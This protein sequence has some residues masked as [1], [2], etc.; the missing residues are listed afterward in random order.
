[1]SPAD[2]HLP[3]RVIGQKSLLDHRLE[4][5][6]TLFQPAAKRSKIDGLEVLEGLQAFVAVVNRSAER[7]AEQRFQ[8][9]FRR[10]A[11]GAGNS[12]D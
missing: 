9:R 2:A 3:R 11:I 10:I 12:F 5:G 6:A 8:N 7:R 1:M 4:S